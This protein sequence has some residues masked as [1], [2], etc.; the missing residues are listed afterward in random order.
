MRSPSDPTRHPA[1]ARTISRRGFLTLAGSSSLVLLAACQASSGPPA[2]PAATQV[3]LAIRTQVPASIPQQAPAA[4][5]APAAPAAAPSVAPVV[6]RGEPKG[7]FTEAYQAAISPSWFDP[8]EN[9]PQ[10]TPYNFCYALHDAM[11]KHMPGQLFA[12]C[13]AE[14]YEIPPDFKS[15]TFKMRPGVKFHDGSPVTPEDVKFTFENYRGASATILKEKVDRIDLPDDRTVKFVFK[16]PFLD[17]LMV[18]GSP[19]SGAGWIVPKAY[20]EKVGKNGFIN[21][22]IGAGPYRFVKQTVGQE[23][24][25][26]AFTDYWRKTPA[27]K[28]IVFKGI[29]EISTRVALLKTGEVDAAH[30]MQGELL[31]ALRKEGQY[32]LAGVR[33]SAIWLELG[34]LDRPDH[35]LKDV[36]VRKAL[37]LLLD[38]QAISDNRLDGLAPLEGN[39]IPEDWQGAIT[40]PSP[41]YDVAQARQ[42]MA[43][44]GV[45]DGYEISAITPLPPNTPW[46]EQILT[47]LRVANI[48]TTV[49]SMERGAFYERM[50]PGPNRFKGLVLQFSSAPGDAASRIRENAVTGGTF[51]GLSLPEVDDRM[52]AY[53]SSVDPAQR[54]KL[55]EE[56]QN[57]L[58]D[59]YWMV[60][61]VRQ[62]S[63]WGL[64]PRVANKTEEINGA[65]P[66]WPFIG[67]YEDIVMKD[68]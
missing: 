62:V 45:G 63:V 47:Q 21:A 1:L 42:L 53:D 41:P 52:K 36:R 60:P 64:G 17:F 31:Q 37:S 46:A 35:P 48:K 20:Y 50:A 34:S 38:R 6:S 12:P 32:R 10:V 8:G 13:L 16:E 59:Q 23:V 67:P 14:S 4:G 30:Q 57:F 39:W 22:P 66:Q 44:A 5:A 27:T 11:V 19:A 61:T 49:Q 68:A 3:P 24:E 58:L 33:S 15:A 9:P 65:V 18:Y 2:T 51:S 26:E 43:D 28:T 54:K 29:P 55:I 25:M 7:K 56:V 40:R